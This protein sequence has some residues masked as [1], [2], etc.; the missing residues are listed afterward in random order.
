LTTLPWG[1]L[2]ALGLMFGSFLNVVIYRVP[3][4]LSVVNPPS[5]CPACHTR[6]RARDNI[7][8]LSWLVLRGRC[9]DCRGPITW[10]YPVVE[11]LTA[12]LVVAVG[13][14]FGFGTPD[15]WAIPAFG[16]VS[17]V[18][19][20]LSAIDLDTHRLPDPVVAAGYMSGLLL[21]VAS[22]AGAGDG[23]DALGR[24]GIGCAAMFTLHF[25][26]MFFYPAGMGFGDVK[27]AGVTG[28]FLAW[29][30]WGPLAVGVMASYLVG[31]VAVG[32]A[33]VL[34]GKTRGVPFGP[35]MFAGAAIGV[36]FGAPI[37][38][39]YLHTIGL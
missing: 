39:A 35:C 3:A 5:A 34:T 18:G 12:A 17:C 25:V 1:F 19:V 36:A 10:R 30:G 14:R 9:R 11:A 21:I 23:L 24:A 16:A 22:V 20:A 8:V 4:G 13:V 37:W 7:P 31:A 32:V 27:L 6:I 2:T 15:V 26:A 38:S 33:A 29:L 28:M